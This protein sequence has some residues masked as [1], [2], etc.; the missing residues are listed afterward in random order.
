MVK[1]VAGVEW[2]RIS[3]RRRVAYGIA[4]VLFLFVFAAIA[5]FALQARRA[6][7]IDMGFMGATLAGGV[8]SIFTAI[9][10]KERR[11]VVDR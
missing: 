5:W 3:T 6:G 10:G 8:F 9:T 2:G 7:M 4:A 1:A 11:K